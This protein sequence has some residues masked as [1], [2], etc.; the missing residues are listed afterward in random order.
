MYRGHYHGFVAIKRLNVTD[1]TPQQLKAFKNEVAVL[2]Y[3]V[4]SFRLF[5]HSYFNYIFEWKIQCTLVYNLE[6]ISHFILC[7]ISLHIED[8]I[9]ILRRKTTKTASLLNF[10]FYLTNYQL[11]MFILWVVYMYKLTILEEN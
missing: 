7:L 3:T 2:R 1:P 8:I 9:V 4:I 6:T 5:M 10:Y 11:K